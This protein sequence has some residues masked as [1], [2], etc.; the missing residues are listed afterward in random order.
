MAIYTICLSCESFNSI[1][2]EYNIHG[3]KQA[4]SCDM[5]K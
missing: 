4:P 5:E 2:R 1:M 3:Y